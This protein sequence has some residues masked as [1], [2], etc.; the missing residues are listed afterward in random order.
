MPFRDHLDEIYFEFRNNHKD[1]HNIHG[2]KGKYTT[3][4]YRK[5]PR[6]AITA[7][8]L[9]AFASGETNSSPEEH[10]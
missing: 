8:L 9:A 7:L 6:A 10:K 1:T 5:L 2:G 3:N 4:M